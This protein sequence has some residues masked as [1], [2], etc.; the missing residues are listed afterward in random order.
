MKRKKMLN[1]LPIFKLI[2][3]TKVASWMLYSVSVFC[4]IPV[5]NSVIFKTVTLVRRLVKK[6]QI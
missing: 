3:E 6:L 4:F 2:L 1:C 5:W